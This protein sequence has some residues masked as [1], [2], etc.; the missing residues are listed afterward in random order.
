MLKRMKNINTYIKLLNS[1]ILIVGVFFTTSRA[2][3]LMSI[4]LLILLFLA[5][6]EATLL[7]IPLYFFL[8]FNIY[9]SK[10]YIVMLI[11]YIYYLYLSIYEK[12]LLKI[13][14]YKE[15][16][17][18]LFLIKKMRFSSFDKKTFY[19]P[20]SIRSDE[21]VSLVVSLLTFIVLVSL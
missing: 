14:T 9:A 4:L 5:R 13:K 19:I 15:E 6:K 18:D 3:F 11:I 2:L 20:F 10:L 16:D 12:N 1:L 7:I 8:H 21:L 17:K